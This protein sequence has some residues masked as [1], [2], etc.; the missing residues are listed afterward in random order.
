MTQYNK[1]QQIYCLSWASNLL[2]PGWGSKPALKRGTQ[3]ELQ[4]SATTILP[5]ILS[6]PKVQQLIGT[7]ELVWGPVVYQHPRNG[8]TSGV[9]DNLMYMAAKRDGDEFD[10]YVI[11]IAGTS[12][13][14]LYSIVEDVYVWETKLWN[15]GKPWNVDLIEK[16]ED[17]IGIRVSA[18]MSL[19][20]K[21]VC[22]MTSDGKSLMDYLKE[23][24]R[25][26]KKPMPIIFTGFSLGGSLSPTL[27]LSF[28]DRRSEWDPENKADLSVL[29]IAGF[30]PGNKSFA[31]HY[32]QNLGKVTDRVWSQVDLIPHWWEQKLLDEAK[33]MY[34]PYLRP[35]LLIDLLIDFFKFLS[36][37]GN[38]QQICSDIPGYSLRYN[39]AISN[40]LDY[41]DIPDLSKLVARIILLHLGFK[42]PRQELIAEVGE[43]IEKAIKDDLIG[44]SPSPKILSEEIINK[45]K[46]KPDIE[47]IIV[48]LQKEKLD[49]AREFLINKLQEIFAENL[50]DF[51]KYVAQVIYQHLHGNP[52]Y[53][54]IPEF[55]KIYDNG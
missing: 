46:I 18:G 24:M 37:D 49:L 30:T 3:S 8:T 5:E 16:V 51:I 23:V 12:K 35:N 31:E 17:K 9:A 41:L 6:A 36:K 55:L 43:I 27:A 28:S 40:Y 48:R 15:N 1:Q 26:T 2:C 25:S 33:T 32:D 44:H 54:N 10:S 50:T 19:A 4:K 38:Y 20:L 22:E 11:S 47:K 7:W 34:E 52:N 21:A 14:S 13:A 53:L 45:A 39:L 42:D 29:P